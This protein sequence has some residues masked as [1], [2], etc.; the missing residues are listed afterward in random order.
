VQ[1]FGNI[2]WLLV[3][4]AAVPGCAQHAAPPSLDPTRVPE[5]GSA[6]RALL[7]AEVAAST[8]TD[9]AELLYVENDSAIS[10]SGGSTAWGFLFHSVTLGEW[11]NVSVQGDADVHE[12]ALDFPFAAPGLPREWIDSNLA[13]SIAEQAGG[14]EFRQATA[15]AVRHAVLSRGVFNAVDGAPTWTVVYRSPTHG[16]LAIVVDAIGG[17]VLDRFEG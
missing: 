16:E 1:Q 6:R 17:Q 5:A 3:L 14:R 12:G 9:D 10:P 13:L 15:A 7:V 4:L 2:L 8:W 11:W